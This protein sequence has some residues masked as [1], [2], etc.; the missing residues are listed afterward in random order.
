MYRCRPSGLG[1]S[2]AGRCI[3][4]LSTES[5]W[6]MDVYACEIEIDERMPSMRLTCAVSGSK[7]IDERKRGKG[8]GRGGAE[9]EE[10]GGLRR[11][12]LTLSLP[13]SSLGFLGSNWFEAQRPCERTSQSGEVSA[14]VEVETLVEGRG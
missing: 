12:T 1:L 5:S 9:P 13:S 10:E 2:F 3:D 8:G 11:G 6:H 14:M 7:G 4:A